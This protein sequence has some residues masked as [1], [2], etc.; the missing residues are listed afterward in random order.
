MKQTYEVKITLSRQNTTYMLRY[1]YLCT[2]FIRSFYETKKVYL[3]TPPI[4]LAF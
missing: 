4:A 1:S 2:S 3:F